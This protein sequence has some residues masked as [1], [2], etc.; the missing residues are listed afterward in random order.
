MNMLPDR[1]RRWGNEVDVDAQVPPPP[2]H[3][4][5]APL[6]Q[7]YLAQ[8]QANAAQ[9][10]LLPPQV[11]LRHPQPPI[12]DR[13]EHRRILRQI[14]AEREQHAEAYHWAQ[15]ARPQGLNEVQRLNELQNHRNV[16]QARLAEI[17]RIRTERRLSDR[18]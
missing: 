14:Q 2:P 12:Q 4:A 1:V 5:P 9:L 18:R 13:N 11:P 10:G 8:M 3:H 16:L 17:D 15:R 6:V 7:P